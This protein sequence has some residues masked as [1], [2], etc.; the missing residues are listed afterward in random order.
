MPTKLE[1]EALRA[2]AL[3]HIQQAQVHLS[4]AAQLTCDLQGFAK[5]WQWIGDAMDKTKALW[6][7]V[8]NAPRPTGV[9][10]Y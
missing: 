8:H 4:A 6:Y 3:H 1:A 10:K 9:S 7:R 2:E 5:P